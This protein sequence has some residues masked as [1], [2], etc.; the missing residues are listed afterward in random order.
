[1][2]TPSQP[3]DVRSTARTARTR[4]A[5]L[6]A[7]LLVLAL[8]EA[9]LCSIAAAVDTPLTRGRIRIT[10]SSSGVE[11]LSFTSNDPAVSFPSPGTNP[12]DPT[13]A[14]SGAG[15]VVEIF[16]SNDSGAAVFVVPSGMGAVPSDP[17]WRNFT[18]LG[19]MRYRYDNRDAP[20]APSAVRR[21]VV[22]Q[23]QRLE[24]QVARSGLRLLE[25]EGI[26]GIRV[27]DAAGN[28]MCAQFD[29]A[30]A[31][32]GARDVPLR[33]NGSRNPLYVVGR[34]APVPPADCSDT[35]L[36]TAS[37]LR[38]DIFPASDAQCDDDGFPTPPLPACGTIPASELHRVR[39]AD[40]LAVCNDGSPAVMF[41]RPAPLETSPGVPNPRRNEWIIWLEGGGSCVNAAECAD[42]W[43]D[44]QQGPY[45]ARKMSSRW[46]DWAIGKV[47]IFGTNASNHFTDFN[48][49]SVKYCSSDAWTGRRTVDQPESDS[50]SPPD[51]SGIHYPRYRVA[52]HGA[53]IVDAVIRALQ[54]PGGVTA[55][56]ACVTMPSLADATEV[57]FSGTSAGGAGATYNANRVAVLIQDG[58][59][60][61]PRVRLVSDAATP[62]Y[63]ADVPNGVDQAEVDAGRAAVAVTR[64]MF[65]SSAESV[66]M[67]AHP[68]DPDGVCSSPAHVLAH[69]MTVPAF[70]QMD[71][72]DNTIGPW[73]YDTHALFGLGVRPLLAGIADG[74]V[75]YGTEPAAQ[76]QVAMFAPRCCHHVTFDNP[77]FFGIL[78]A[79]PSNPGLA[80]RRNMNDTL[81]DWVTDVSVPAFIDSGGT[82]SSGCPGT[83]PPLEAR[84][85]P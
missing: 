66:C 13:I 24:I 54:Q 41:V 68:G 17:G 47:G 8:A 14:G 38:P 40:P 63:E 27:T 69:H 50:P 9:G 56:D 82:Y 49:V 76:A 52:Y 35:A 67:A 46:E 39:L 22:K 30:T 45:S 37:F 53:Y 62:P 51:G 75:L 83:G 44:L 2:K 48:F 84:P 80:G 19:S 65:G 55:D 12:G 59:T 18:I 7:A 20:E 16:G 70:V 60:G 33:T 21:F 73:L 4:R 1:M 64:A 28:R 78:V 26:V 29:P 77:E 79:D 15:A 5:L 36:N 58:A 34:V 42:R 72:E 74:S 43:C 6:A 11:R 32:A 85:C 81:W 71:V 23:G 3:S 31:G 57:L 61:T 10:R 25:P